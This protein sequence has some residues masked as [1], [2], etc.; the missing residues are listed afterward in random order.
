MKSIARLIHHFAVPSHRNNYRARALHLDTLT[1]LVL[2]FL[3]FSFAAPKAS[4]LGVAK[5]VTS[6][7]L[8]QRTN[9]QRRALDLQP[10]QE[11][12]KLNQAAYAKAQDM[13]ADN[14][15]D[16]FAP[17]GAT[18]WDFIVGAGYS[19][20]YAG[21]NLAYNFMF[22]DDVVNA[23]M[24]SPT[25]RENILRPEYTEIG[26][27][28]VNGTLLGEETTVV[29]QMFGTPAGGQPIAQAEE[30]NSLVPQAQAEEIPEESVIVEETVP[31]EE[32]AP[33]ETAAEESEDI[34]VSSSTSTSE[35]SSAILGSGPIGLH[36]LT[37]NSSTIIIGL[38]LFVLFM[39]LVIAYRLKLVRV[40][41]KNLAHILFLG[42][43][44]AGVFIIKSGAIL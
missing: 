18:P 36:A 3:I 4:I 32:T 42:A 17:D 37:F 34:I 26:F 5:D 2:F 6:G 16:H 9:D 21:E 31:A 24:D 27:A 10:L 35:P 22:S 25:H 41:S 13:F 14:Y 44:L 28:V 40:T 15:W 39:D 23:W 11:N 19:Y 20:K 30:E 8:L 33:A 12:Q 43:I 29:V 1:I 7:V 38:L